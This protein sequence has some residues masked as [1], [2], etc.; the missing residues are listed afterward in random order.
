[1]ETIGEAAAIVEDVRSGGEEALR[2]QAER[3][4]DLEPGGEIILDRNQLDETLDSLPAEARGVLERV[5]RRIRSFAQA[6]RDSLQDLDIAVA[7]GRAGHRWIPVSSAGAYA[8]GGRYPLPSSVLMTVIPARV[9]GVEAVWVASPRPTP[10]TM[11]AAAVAGADGLLAVGGAQAIAALAFG[12]IS[13]ACD[14]VV[15][16][17]NRWVTAAKK[18]LFGEIGIDGLAG[19]SEILVIADE[20]ADPELVGADLLAQAEHDDDAVPMLIT[21]SVS[22]ADEVDQ[23]IGRQL[24]DLP[25]SATASRALENGFCLIVESLE[26]AVSMSDRIAPEHLALHVDEPARL[27]EGLGSYGSLFVGSGTAEAFADYGVGPNH[28]LPTG[29]GAR[30]QSGLSVLTFLRSPTWATI[31]DPEPLVDDTMLLARLEG[32]EAHARAAQIRRPL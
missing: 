27:V 30:Y 18:Y 16:P 21:T 3:L 29:G 15:G 4:G 26:E 23:A 2:R 14:L 22:L 24:E 25:T 13:P 1:L 9:A 11:A 12:T 32:L 8:P 7:G 28:V 19:P 6:Q 5:A 31:D 17:G 20:T 10:V